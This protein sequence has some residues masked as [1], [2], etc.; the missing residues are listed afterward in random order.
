M[1]SADGGGDAAA[2]M[3]ADVA[4]LPR[5]D[6]SDDAVGLPC[7][8]ECLTLTSTAAVIRLSGAGASICATARILSVAGM[9]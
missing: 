6:A 5:G 4:L 8:G 9:V 7:D 1:F 2:A 3:A